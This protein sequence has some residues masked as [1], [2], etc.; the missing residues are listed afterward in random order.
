MM[1]PPLI[2]VGDGALACVAESIAKRTQAYTRVELRD[3]AADNIS[4]V[5]IAELV[6]HNPAACVV[7]AAIGVQA[8]NYA[9]FDLWAKFR[10]AGYRCAK[11]VDPTAHVDETAELE[12]NCLVDVHTSVGPG[13]HVG[14]GTILSSGVR[15]AGAAR[16][17][18]FSWVGVNST[19]GAD[20]KIGSHVILGPGVHILGASTVGGHCE[21]AIPGRY[22]N[23]SDGTFISHLFDTPA[24]IY[25]LP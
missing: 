5:D 15:V 1:Q 22:E 21:I 2:V 4:S 24:R 23:L 18:R 3:L 20:A 6:G 7:F 25:S 19:I 12:D 16:V 14:S 10:F 17:G 8:L 13:S 9:R 11:L